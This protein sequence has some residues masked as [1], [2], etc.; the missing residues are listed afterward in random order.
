MNFLA[1]LLPLALGAT[2]V[3]QANLN[4]YTGTHLGLASAVFL[5]AAIF[6]VLGIFLYFI[7]KLSPNAVPEFM[8]VKPALS[9]Y[10]WLFLVPGFCG[11]LYVLGLPWSIQNI[12]PALSFILLIASQVT[13][14]LGLEYFQTGAVPSAL[15]VLGAAFVLLG[16]V[17]V[18][19]FK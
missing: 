2:A 18:V 11:F 9:G 8:R 17:L 12:G 3:T 19:K 6:F 7:A 4:R 15:R 16:S 14:S 10:S 1:L 5:N 13:V